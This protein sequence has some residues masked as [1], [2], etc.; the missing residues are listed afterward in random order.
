LCGIVNAKSGRCP[1]DCAF[2][3]QSAH[4]QTDT[5]IYGLVETDD[6]V[7]AAAAGASLHANRFGIVTSGTGIDE[8]PELDRICA[9]VARIAAD[10]QLSPCASLG[11]MSESALKQ[12]RESGLRGYHHNLETSRS[13]YPQIC[14]THDYDDDVATVAAAKRLGLM[15]CSGG[16]FGL[17]ETRAQRVELAMT[18]RDLDVDS[19]PINFLVPVPGTRLQDAAPLD[20]LECLTTIAAY[21]FMLPHATVKV[22]AGRE[23]NLRDLSSWIFYAGANGMMVGNY[24]TTTGRDPALDLAMIRVL[25]LRPINE[26]GLALA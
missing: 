8:G 17:G 7:R 20:P 25:G 12:L 16:I 13:F 9:A 11:I 22:C 5:P 19:V 3:A 21:R 26:T 24:L 1:E 2:C 15:T 10:G 14:G 4:H 23:R 18:L 6:L